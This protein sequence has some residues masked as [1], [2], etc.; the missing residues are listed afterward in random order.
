MPREC[1]GLPRPIVPPRCEATSFA[2]SHC[3]ETCGF[4][5]AGTP[6]HDQLSAAQCKEYTDAGRLA[7]AR[8]A[9]T[10]MH[11]A[12]SSADAPGTASGVWTANP[13]DGL[14]YS[15]NAAR[16]PL[17]TEVL[18]ALAGRRILFLGDSNTRY[19]YLALAHFLH[20]SR[21]PQRPAENR[22]SVCH[23]D[24]VWSVPRLRQAGSQAMN[25]EAAYANLSSVRLF[26][27]GGEGEGVPTRFVAFE[28][29]ANA[30][31]WRTFFN[32]S[33]NALGGR[34]VC[35]CDRAEGME[36]RF[37]RSSGGDGGRPP[38]ELAFSW[39]VSLRSH[40]SKLREWPSGGWEA[41]GR[42]VSR[43]CNAG[44]CNAA[45]RTH[46]LAAG[47]IV[48]KRLRP[49]RPDTVILGPGPWMSSLRERG[50]R[51]LRAFML[52]VKRRVVGPHGRAIFK[53]CPRGNDRVHA[54]CGNSDACDA[55]FRALLNETGWELF[56]LHRVSDELF[57]FTESCRRAASGR[58]RW[59]S[60]PNCTNP[61]SDA[62][63]FQ[64]DAYREVNRLLLQILSS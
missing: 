51:R 3:R 40:A 9:E 4:C 48:D 32:Q 41:F 61:Y 62:V 12:C 27:G 50:R 13:R 59:W 36:N 43:V 1:Y 37:F 33:V 18:D 26:L 17:A 47:A 58:A 22:F 55:P 31:K 23:E 19:Q 56:D 35:E 29:W 60:A 15:R 20:T 7:A 16:M 14:R 53:A 6:C 54:G 38:V 8:R 42:R 34:E 52:S 10:P 63:H 28:G 39:F 49:L 64:C 45:H 57:S 30:W 46:K 2:C 11:R 5:A 24:S 44:A 25:A 21:W